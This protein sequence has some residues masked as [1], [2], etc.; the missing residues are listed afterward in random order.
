MSRSALIVLPLLLAACSEFDLKSIPSSET[1]T[2]PDTPATTPPPGPALEITPA[3]FEFGSLNIP[4]ED[5]TE[6][7]LTSV[8]DADVTITQL[9]YTSNGLLALDDSGLQ[10]PVTLS[11]G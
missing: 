1:V 6:L 7:T 3:V 4:C 9:D 11:P 5:A 10:L 8:G 2:T